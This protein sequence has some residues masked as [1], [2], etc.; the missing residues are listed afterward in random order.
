M[1]YSLHF[2]SVG[3][4]RELGSEAPNVTLVM[5]TRVVIMANEVT[6]DVIV[7]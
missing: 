2:V 3:R 1:L 6:E 4:M 5:K 7:L